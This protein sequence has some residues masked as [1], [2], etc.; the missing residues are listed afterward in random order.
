MQIFFT[1]LANTS[2]TSWSEKKKKQHFHLL[3][4]F[5]FLSIQGIKKRWGRKLTV[6]WADAADALHLHT[7]KRLASDSLIIRLSL[8]KGGFLKLR[9]CS[10][11]I[12][13]THRGKWI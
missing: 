13:R 4:L 12:R 8:S 2:R 6:R 10:F 1:S 3:L 11:R 9:R 5:F 7:H